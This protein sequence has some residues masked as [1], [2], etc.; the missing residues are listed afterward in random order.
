MF[1]T[2]FSPQGGTPVGHGGEPATAMTPDSPSLLVW[3]AWTGAL[4][5]PSVTWGPPV[6]PHH[7]Q[8]QART[9]SLATLVPGQRAQGNPRWMATLTRPKTPP[10]SQLL[11]PAGWAGDSREAAGVENGPRVPGSCRASTLTFRSAFPLNLVR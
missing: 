3:G 9:L 2:F 6:P 1:P 4:P 8:K 5:L 7:P 10:R 11:V